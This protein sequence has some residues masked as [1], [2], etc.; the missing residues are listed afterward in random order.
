MRGWFIGV[1]CLPTIGGSGTSSVIPVCLYVVRIYVL[2]LGGGCEGVVL[3][4]GWCWLES[5][6]IRLSRLHNY[7]NIIV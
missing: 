6:G 4:F 7:S 3:V 1:G 2:V 5:S